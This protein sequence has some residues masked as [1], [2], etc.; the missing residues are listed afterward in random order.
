MIE[1]G[2]VSLFVWALRMD[3]TALTLFLWRLLDL[4]TKVRLPIIRP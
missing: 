1:S 3:R 4:F 2:M